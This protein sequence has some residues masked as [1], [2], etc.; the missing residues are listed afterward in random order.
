M[1]RPDVAATRDVPVACGWRR[2]LTT[3]DWEA[4][5]YDLTV[6]A[7]DGLGNEA[8]LRRR[9]RVDPRGAYS[10]WLDGRDAGLG[11]AYAA[12]RFA[13][14]DPSAPRFLVVVLAGARAP[15]E[16]Q[17][18]PLFAVASSPDVDQAIRMILDSDAAYG[19]LV[20]DDVVLEPHAL[21][22]LAIEAASEPRP[23]LIYSD[24]DHRATDGG[25]HRPFF[26]PGWSPELLLGVDYVGPFVCLSKDAARRA[27]DLDEAPIERL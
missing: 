21:H 8:S 19:V 9:V 7:R 26:K 5:L 17:H 22:A 10:Q 23:H 15:I 4:G 6:T 11:D 25:R 2:L 12:R 13:D 20:T 18:Y 24:H 14:T 1:R 3:T 27:L 16:P